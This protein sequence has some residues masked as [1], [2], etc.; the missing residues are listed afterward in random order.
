MSTKHTKPTTSHPKLTNL[1][2]R[3]I[4][5]GKLIEQG[6][7]NDEIVE[8]TDCSLSSVKRWRKQMASQG[9]ESLLPKP[10]PGRYCK[11]TEEQ[12]EQLKVLLQQG[13]RSFGYLSDLWTCKRIA[14][15]IR[16]EFGVDYHPMSQIGRAH[17]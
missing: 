2:Y 9:C 8:I 14:K 1:Q 7:D 10:H 15:V 13:A 4:Q 17:V 11:L 5:A 3:R 16:Q 12:K 6:F